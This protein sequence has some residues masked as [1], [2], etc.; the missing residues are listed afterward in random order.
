MGTW[1]SR[2]INGFPRKTEDGD[3]TN[4]RVGF[5]KEEGKSTVCRQERWQREGRSIRAGVP[6]GDASYVDDGLCLIGGLDCIMMAA[7]GR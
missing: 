7:I 6:G 4:T 3:I 5:P 2:E 1:P